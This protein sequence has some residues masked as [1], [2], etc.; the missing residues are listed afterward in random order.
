MAIHR[1]NVGPL[2]NNTYVLVCEATKKAAIV[3][4]SLESEKIWDWIVEQGLTLEYVINTHGHF[5]HT[6]NNAYFVERSGAKLLIHELDLPQL[7]AL[8]A[9]AAAFGLRAQPSPPP[10]SYLTDGQVLCVGEL[11]FDVFFTPGHSP[12]HVVLYTPGTLIGGD[13]LFRES[14]G[15]TDLPGASFR[16]LERSIKER[17]FTLP[18]ETEVLPGH[19]PTT[20]IG[21]ERIYNPFV[22]TAAQLGIGR[23]WMR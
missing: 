20:T 18:A 12:G 6:F 17:L 5:D 23:L 10:D 22:G 21:H 2:D 9:K 13:T 16:E 8:P 1:F 11:A 4:P 14:I 7:E 15:R 3:D 19:G